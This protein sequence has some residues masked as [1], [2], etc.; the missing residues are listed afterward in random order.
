MEF[1][2]NENYDDCHL[3]IKEAR[4]YSDFGIE[5]GVP[6]YTQFQNDPDRFLFVSKPETR[7]DL[8]ENYE[9]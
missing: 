7:K 9:P 1:I 6:V 5:K 2:K 4:D 8:W 3:I